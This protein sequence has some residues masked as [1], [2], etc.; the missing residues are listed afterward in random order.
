MKHIEEGISLSMSDA[1][2][3]LGVGVLGVVYFDDCVSQGNNKGIP[4]SHDNK[5]ISSKCFNNIA[6]R[7]NGVSVELIKYRKKS[8]LEKLFS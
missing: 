7:I 8:F 4:V 6:K 5:G 1:V 3:V 2:D